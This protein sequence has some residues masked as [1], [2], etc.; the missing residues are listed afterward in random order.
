LFS[1][2]LFALPLRNPLLAAIGSGSYFIY[3]WHIFIIM[4]LRD[5]AGLREFGPAADFAITFMVTAAISVAALLAIRM[6]APLRLSRWLG[7]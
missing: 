3:L 1:T 4:I 5:H 2:L 6:L 7:A